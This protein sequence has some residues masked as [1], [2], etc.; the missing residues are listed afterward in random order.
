M[1]H[2]VLAL[3]LRQSY[4]TVAPPCACS[5]FTP[6]AYVEQVLAQAPALFP[7]QRVIIDSAFGWQDCEGAWKPRYAL[8]MCY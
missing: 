8:W 7:C 3:L 2:F 6:S 4:I 1:A 5:T